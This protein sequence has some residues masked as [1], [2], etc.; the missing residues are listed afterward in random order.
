MEGASTCKSNITLSIRTDEKNSRNILLTITDMVQKE[1]GILITFV[2]SVLHK[3]Y[4][5]MFPSEICHF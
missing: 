5:V 4:S 2:S 3:C 1:S